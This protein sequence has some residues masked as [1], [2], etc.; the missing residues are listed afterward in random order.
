MHKS[1][2]GVSQSK[3]MRKTRKEK[4]NPLSDSFGDN[5]QHLRT[6]YFPQTKPN[7]TILKE[8]QVKV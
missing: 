8:N 1:I 3:T 2:A 4:R 7:G 6:M 5:Q